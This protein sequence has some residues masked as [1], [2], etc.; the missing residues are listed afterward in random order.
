[1]NVRSGPV[2]KT[3]KAGLRATQ[4]NPYFAF[5][6][7]RW[8]FG[9]VPTYKMMTV[10]LKAADLGCS[11]GFSLMRDN[12]IPISWDLSTRKLLNK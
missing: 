1:M 3:A 8:R 12:S 5:I 10:G 4:E 2:L 6:K 9:C 7:K 11:R